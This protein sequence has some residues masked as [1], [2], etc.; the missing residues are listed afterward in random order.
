MATIK[1]S[2]WS[3]LDWLTVGLYFLL[4]VL[5][6]FN[7][8]SAVYN[9]DQV[10]TFSLTSRYG[11]QFIWIIAA[12]LIILV[13]MVVDSKFYSAFSFPIY[14]IVI[15]LLVAVL[16][17]G[18]RVNGAQSWFVI[19]SVRIQ[20]SEF[21]KFATS[22]GLAK[23]LSQYNFKPKKFKSMIQFLLICFVPALL[24][25]MQNDTGSAL[26]FVIFFLVFFRE[27]MPSVYLLSGLLGIALFVL[28]LLYESYVVI[29]VIEILAFIAFFVLRR[30]L[31]WAVIGA[32][33]LAGVSVIFWQIA[34]FILPNISATYVFLAALVVT[35]V[36]FLVKTYKFKLQEMYLVLG[37]VFASIAFTYSVDYVF[38][39]ILDDHQ[40]NRIN[41]LLGIESDPYG[42]G[43]NVNQSKIAI[44]SGGVIGKGYLQGTQTKFR[45]V[46]EQSTDF[47]FCTV[48]EEWGFA[49]TSLIISLFLFLIIR[50]IFLAERQK[51]TYSRIYGYCVASIIFFH[52]AINIGMTIGLAPVIGIPLPFF[53][54]GGSSLWGF[55]FLLFIFLKLDT[56]RNELVN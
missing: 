9:E 52:V 31:K 4:V 30:N 13:A 39:D 11:R 14:S 45:F 43:Y 54:Y 42:A 22:L 17:F 37:I 36:W 56:N 21:A 32:L 44:G 2:I 16:I 50:L 48:G 24:I 5:G 1:N 51:S 20:P 49:G 7:I 29:V 8:Y 46:P 27:G 40:Q 26:V 25:L 34:A 10:D 35:S 55:T 38:N 12:L 33:V 19:G 18:V 41:N 15:V 47:I 53:S 28:S 23:F 6:W 3:N